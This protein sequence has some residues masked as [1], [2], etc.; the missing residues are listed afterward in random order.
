MC[1]V[2][3]G[4]SYVGEVIQPWKN[5]MTIWTDLAGLLQVDASVRRRILYYRSISTEWML[6]PSVDALHGAQLGIP[7]FPVRSEGCIVGYADG[8]DFSR[9]GDFPAPPDGFTWQTCKRPPRVPPGSRGVPVQPSAEASNPSSGD[10]VMQQSTH[11]SSVPAA[12]NILPG[13][14]DSE[15]VAFPQ[16]SNQVE[17]RKVLKSDIRRRMSAKQWKVQNVRAPP[18]NVK[19]SRVSLR[20]T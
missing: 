3:E 7:R 15:Y 9:R 5:R 16:A 2:S 14:H 19:K 6:R 8:Q 17:V 4:F 13:K 20:K 12:D 18:S 10:A 11:A 1:R